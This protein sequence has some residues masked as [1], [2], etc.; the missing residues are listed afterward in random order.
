MIN[1]G[2]S[3]SGVI[4][5]IFVKKLRDMGKWLRINGEAIYSSDPWLYQNDTQ[6]PD[7]WYTSKSSTE[8][9]K[10]D[11]SHVYAIVL[12]YPYDTAGVNLFALGDLFDSLTKV[13]LLGYSGILKVRLVTAYH[14]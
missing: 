7:V 1:V 6:T 12:S 14:V 8:K 5:P 2:P 13:E 4:E 11:R 10:T 9:V 3:K